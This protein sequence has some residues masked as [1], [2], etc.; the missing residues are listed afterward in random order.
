MILEIL[1]TYGGYK[2]IKGLFDDEVIYRDRTRIERTQEELA[3]LS[4]KT[5]IRL[6]GCDPLE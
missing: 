4:R 6:F 1:A 5:R 2:I 3:K